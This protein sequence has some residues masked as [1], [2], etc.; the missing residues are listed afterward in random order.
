MWQHLALKLNFINTFQ[1]NMV[2]IDQMATIPGKAP[3]KNNPYRQSYSVT[4]TITI[5]IQTWGKNAIRRATT[6]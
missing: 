1:D 5:S 2:I 6:V 3:R 4:V